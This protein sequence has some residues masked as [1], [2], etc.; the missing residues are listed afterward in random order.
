MKTLLTAAVVLASLAGTPSAA[1]GNVAAAPSG[2]VIPDSY[3]VVAERSQVER[4]GGRIVREFKSF[5]GFEVHMN[6]SQARRVAASGYVEQNAVIQLDAGILGTQPNPPSWGLDRIDQRNLPLDASYTF[7]NNGAG[8]RA[9]ILST[10]IRVTH[11]DFGGRAIHGYDSVD[12]DFIAT[13]CQGSGTHLAGIV[14]GANYGVAKGATLVAMRIVNCTGAGTIAQVV[15]GIDWVTNNAVRPAVAVLAVGSAANTVVDN[16][17]KA[18]IASGISYSVV[19]GGSGSDACNFSP[20]RVTDALTVAAS[21]NTDT[22]SGSSG[23][24]PCVDLYAPGVGITS[25]WYTTDTAVATISGTTPASAH[26]AGAAALIL[27]AHPTWS[28]IQV[29]NEITADATPGVLTGVPPGTAN[30]LLYVDNGGTTPCLYTN[31]TDVPI[32]DYPGAAVYS[33]INVPCAGTGSAAAPVTVNIVHT[34]KGDLTVELVSPDGSTFLL[35][36]R[37]GGSA[38]NINQTYIV[39]LSGEGRNGVWRLRVRD[40]ARADTGYINSWT[41]NP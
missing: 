25:T 7:P 36:N 6:A 34:W 3:I 11:T 33:D 17:V 29:H 16:A 4:H 19:A 40:H 26:V 37:T 15:A 35:H 12:N 23:F 41:V 28:A 27:F 5:N 10:G 24:G 31:G 9:Y 32:P 18:S 30:L 20:G 14:G 8:V 13:D 39:D 21:S 1:Y 38:D 22:V 2:Q